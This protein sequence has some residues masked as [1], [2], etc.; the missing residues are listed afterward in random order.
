MI[1]RRA[2]RIR[3]TALLALVFL[4]A[5][6]LGFPQPAYAHAHLVST[7]PA[8]GAVLQT[9]PDRVLFTFDEAVRGVPDG[10]QVFDS[11]GELVEARP[12][13][14][15]AELEVVLS[16]QLGNGTTVITWR[17]A[18]EDGHPV[19][20]ALTFSVGA[21][22]PVITPP[23]TDSGSVP[24]VPW[25]LTLTRALGYIGLLLATGLIAFAA[26]FLPTD[27]SVDRPRRRVAASA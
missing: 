6:L 24:E 14:K 18:S 22:T 11:Q 4:P 23:P 20:G 15:G 12:T 27:S 13:V 25:A 10:V 9:A 21:P 19:N 7:N 5:L 16:A 1:G 26:M 2:R 8:E 17:V 3:T